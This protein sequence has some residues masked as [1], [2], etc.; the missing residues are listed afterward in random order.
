[1][2]IGLALL[3]AASLTAGAV[4]A[5]PDP[6]PQVGALLRD[7]QAARYRNVWV[8]TLPKGEVVCGEVNAKNRAGGYEGYARFVVFNDQVWIADDSVLGPT[9]MS[10]WLT[11]CART[12][13]AYRIPT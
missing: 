3:L 11:F 4:Q 12:P 6:R 10:A 8:H 1:M 7:P 13:V 5:A 9:G 2:R